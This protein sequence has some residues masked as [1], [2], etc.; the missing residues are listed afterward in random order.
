MAGCAAGTCAGTE[1]GTGWAAGTS[2]FAAAGWLPSVSSWSGVFWL[3]DFGRKNPPSR[4]LRFS[5]RGL[6]S[7]GMAG[8]AFVFSGAAGSSSRG[9]S[10]CTFPSVRR[11]GWGSMGVRR[12]PSFPARLADLGSSGSSSY[13]G[14]L[15]FF[16]IRAPRVSRRATIN[17]ALVTTARMMAAP[18]FVKPVSPPIA[19]S[20]ES[21]PPDSQASPVSQSVGNSRTVVIIV[22][23][24]HAKWPSAPAKRG[25]SM[26]QV[27]RSRT[28]RPWWQKRIRAE[29]NMA[30]AIR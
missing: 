19:S 26:A 11:R 17:S 9:K 12:T 27:T 21:T 16:S 20:P 5:G 10:I 4:P 7:A 30:G 2:G 14:R 3:S 1:A 15:R 25:K 22:S 29:P 24:H 23:L 13:W 28:G 18:T 8:A 6:S